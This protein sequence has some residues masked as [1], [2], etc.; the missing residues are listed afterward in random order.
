MKNMET[1]VWSVNGNVTAKK[2]IKLHGLLSGEDF[3]FTMKPGTK[4]DTPLRGIVIKTK[5]GFAPMARRGT[6]AGRTIG[7]STI[8]PTWQSWP[9]GRYRHLSGA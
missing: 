2:T 3:E 6:Q 7:R 8:G 4:P 1:G 9:I 5:P